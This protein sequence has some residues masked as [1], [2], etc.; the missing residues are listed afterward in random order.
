M[1]AKLSK[2]KLFEMSERMSMGFLRYWSK[3]ADKSQVE[4]VGAKNPL[5][6]PTV[7]PDTVATICYT[8]VRQ[9]NYTCT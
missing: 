2:I 9:K 7:T 4:E 5:P 8:S 1:W 3:K 6:P